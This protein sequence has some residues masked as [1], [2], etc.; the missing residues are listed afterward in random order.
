MSPIYSV[1]AARLHS[2]LNPCYCLFVNEIAATVQSSIAAR[3]STFWPGFTTAQQSSISL[4][5]TAASPGCKRWTC[6]PPETVGAIS[7]GLPAVMP[8]ST[9]N[10]PPVICRAARTREMRHLRDIAGFAVVAHRNAWSLRFR[11][12]AGSMTDRSGCDAI[13]SDPSSADDQ[14]AQLD[15]Q[16]LAQARLRPFDRPSSVGGLRPEPRRP[17]RR[18]GQTKCG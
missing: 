3:I 18:S 12:G 14:E 2:R 6:I 5:A 4:I 1:R 9:T 7:R 8:P 13:H 10:T 15:A 17:T 11:I 16:A